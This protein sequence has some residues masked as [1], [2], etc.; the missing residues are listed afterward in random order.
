MSGMDDDLE[1]GK[2]LLGWLR[3]TRPRTF[4]KREAFQALKGPSHVLIRRAA[5]VD[6]ATVVLKDHGWIFP[7]DDFER[8]TG[9][10]GNNQSPVYA[11][12]PSLCEVA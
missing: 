9:R 7:L 6:A 3:R 8:A 5:D 10:P 11:V 12:H 2:L 4:S 1:R